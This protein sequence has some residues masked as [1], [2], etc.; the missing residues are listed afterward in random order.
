VSLNVHPPHRAIPYRS[1]G[2]EYD[3]RYMQ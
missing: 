1:L 3:I 2:W